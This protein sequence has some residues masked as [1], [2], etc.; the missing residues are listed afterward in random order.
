[1]KRNQ[2]V[3]ALVAAPN[4]YTTNAYAASDRTAAHALIPGDRP[5]ITATNLIMD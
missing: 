2:N 3:N 1:M 5:V 4:A